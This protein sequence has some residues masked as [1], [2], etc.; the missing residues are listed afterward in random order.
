MALGGGCGDSPLSIAYL[1]SKPLICDS[2][3]TLRVR[4]QWAEDIMEEGTPND[5]RAV[6]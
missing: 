2:A 3:A 6:I 1:D 4:E 5:F